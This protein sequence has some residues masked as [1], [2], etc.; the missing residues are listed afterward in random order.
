MDTEAIAAFDLLSRM[1]FACGDN[2]KR[3]QDELEE[4]LRELRKDA[5][6]YRW[7]RAIPDEVRADHDYNPGEGGWDA[8]I[9][10]RGLNKPGEELQ[11]GDLDDAIDAAMNG[12]NPELTDAHSASSEE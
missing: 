7:L 10:W 2:G 12:A 6:R 3:M 4:Y 5:E 9:F 8:P 1:R 11:G